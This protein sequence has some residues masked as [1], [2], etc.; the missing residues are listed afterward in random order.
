MAYQLKYIL[1]HIPWFSQFLVG[2]I[3]SEWS[4]CNYLLNIMRIL[5]LDA[6][7]VLFYARSNSSSAPGL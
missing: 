3:Q 5:R 1:D 2:V 7:S 4:V 6:I